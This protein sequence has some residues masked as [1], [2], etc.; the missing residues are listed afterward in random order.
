MTALTHEVSLSRSIIHKPAVL[1]RF[2]FLLP[3][4]LA[5]LASQEAFC[6]DRQTVAYSLPAGSSRFTQEQVIEVGDVPGHKL[7]IFES[8]VDYRDVNLAFGGVKM[9]ESFTRG[10]SDYTNGTGT[11]N[12][13][14]VYL[15]EDGNKLFAKE[16][17]VGQVT[18]TADGAIA[19]KYAVM[20]TFTGGTGRFR[21]IRGQLRGNVVRV[22]G[23]SSIKADVNGEYWIEE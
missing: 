9:K 21:G 1:D 19:L 13:Y 2:K 10:S 4:C 20:A 7:R 17:G 6:Q 23:E 16:S 5:F 11:A 12:N 14:A 3:A 8:H 15:L 22:P 18:V